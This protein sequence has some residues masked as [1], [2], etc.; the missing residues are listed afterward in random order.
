MASATNA[1]ATSYYDMSR[2]THYI[3]RTAP[4]DGVSTD[5]S[6]TLDEL[7]IFDQALTASQVAALDAALMTGFSAPRPSG[8]VVGDILNLIGWPD[9][10]R[11]L[12]T[13]EIIVRPP[14]NP[15]GLS[16]LEL[17]QLVAQTEG[18]R[19]FV[20]AQGRVA[21][22]DR[23]R[24]LVDPA[25]SD[26]QYNFTD[27]DRDTNPTDVGTVDGSLRVTLDDRYSYEAAEVTRD[28]G[29]AQ[30]SS[31]VA[32]PTRTWKADGLL[33]TDDLQSLNLA[34]W[35]AFRYGT[36]QA[37]SDTWAVDP[38]VLPDD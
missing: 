5:S 12:D 2:G 32:H 17:L 36:P 22:R 24:F 18:G 38:E 29:Y 8:E 23:G 6:F 15:A 35:I 30:R 19:L 10:L 16:A 27:E 37:R 13:G 3:V 33:F 28:G 34:E 21:F 14:A 11:D 4:G 31:L 1:S 9:E 20:D 7:M 25:E 26:V